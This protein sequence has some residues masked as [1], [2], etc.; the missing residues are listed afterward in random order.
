MF[1]KIEE[2]EKALKIFVYNL[3]DYASATEYCLRNSK[4]S[5]KLRKHLFQLLFQLLLSPANNER[6]KLLKPTLELLN[7]HLI[8]S[9]DIP[10]LIEILPNNWSVKITSDFLQNVLQ[11][12]LST[13]NN[14]SVEKNICAV[15]KFSL[16]TRMHNL[17]KEQLYLDD[18][19]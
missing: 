6:E 3:Q 19:R 7:S 9:F 11:S 18:D 17:R 2:H 5:T 1:L 4:D 12:N 13:K 15:H 14:Y 8:S 16:Q 10:K